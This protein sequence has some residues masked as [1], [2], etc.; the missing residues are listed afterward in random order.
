[1]LGDGPLDSAR[2]LELETGRYYLCTA[3]RRIH[4]HLEDLWINDDAETVRLADM[5]LA[6]RRTDGPQH[7]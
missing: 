3:E 1:M 5:L 4:R 6:K 7:Q 2:K